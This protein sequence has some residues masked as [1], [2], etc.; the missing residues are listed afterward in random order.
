MKKL[1]V[2][3]SGNI[4]HY[5]HVI[6][7]EPLDSNEGRVHRQQLVI[8]ATAT[9]DELEEA[10]TLLKEQD[11]IRQELD[12]LRS[13]LDGSTAMKK[14]E[15]YE[16]KATGEWRLRYGGTTLNRDNHLQLVADVAAMQSRLAELEPLAEAVEYIETNN[17]R[18]NRSTQTDCSARIWL[19]THNEQRLENTTI[20]GGG[21]TLFKAVADYI[22]KHPEPEEDESVKL[23]KRVR[24]S[25]RFTD[26]DLLADIDAYLAARKKHPEPEEKPEDSADKLLKG[27]L[28]QLRNDENYRKNGIY[29]PIIN[30]IRNYLA[31][32]SG[33]RK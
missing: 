23:F 3:S 2:F 21:P 20:S 11:N 32:R 18:V 5:D 10:R 1:E 31:A 15:S 33:E 4:L 8:D 6:I 14:L 30:R 29:H 7:G 17:L 19:V 24:I 26:K 12:D 13:R 16:L 9:Q 28:Y 22:A 27:V 25:M